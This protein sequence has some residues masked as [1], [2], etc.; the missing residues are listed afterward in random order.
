MNKQKSLD[1]Y[2]AADL[3]RLKTSK[4]I[5]SKIAPNGEIF[6]YNRHHTARAILDSARIPESS[7]WFARSPL[8]TES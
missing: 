1:K 5:P 8:F 7:K 3:Q 6:M 2:S 4:P